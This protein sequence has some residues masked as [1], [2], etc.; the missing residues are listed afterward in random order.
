LNVL[1]WASAT[2]AAVAAGFRWLGVSQAEHYIPGSASRF[3][4]RWAKSSPANFALAAASLGFAI[5][6]PFQ[7]LACIGVVLVCILWP[8]GLPFAGV[9]WTRRAKTLAGLAFVVFGV[10]A[11]AAAVVVGPWATCVVPLL[12]PLLVDFAAQVLEP[13]ERRFAKRWMISATEKLSKI[14]PT[15]VGITGSFGKTS[16]KL[17]VLDLVGAD[18]STVASPASF[19]NQ[20]GLSMTVNQHLEAGTE[21]LVAEMGTYGPG[22]IARLC[23]W[24]KPEIAAISSIGPVH[25]E[26]MGSLERIAQA[27]AEILDSAKVAVLNIDYPELR[28]LAASARPTQR[29]RTVSSTDTTADVAVIDDDETWRVNIGDSEWAVPAPPG[30]HAGN[31]AVALAIS[32]ELGVEAERLVGRLERLRVP[33][34]RT[35]TASTEAGVVVIDDTFNSNPAGAEAA[36]AK[37]EQSASGTL[38]VVTPGMVELGRSQF[39]ENRVFGQRAAEVADHVVVVGRT[40][41]RALMKGA[42]AK[43]IALPDRAS[44]VEWVRSKLQPGDGVLYENDLPNHYP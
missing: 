32:L 20:A 14:D 41:R 35:A 40:N 19:N 37:L 3:A 33:D 36:L 16:T 2:V 21:V 22:E 34:H 13:V 11:V 44:A 10:A 38:V 29:L 18:V 43:G 25:L 6:L 28:T 27:K 1:F 42:G 15:V 4:G 31:A 23:S 30:A 7:G 17:H 5:L 24:L 8:V 12:A 39:Q 9:K 26:R